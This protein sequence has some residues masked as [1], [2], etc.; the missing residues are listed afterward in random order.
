MPVPAYRR[1]APS[2]PLVI[3]SL[4]TTQS[5]FR[6]GWGAPSSPPYGGPLPTLTP[7]LAPVTWAGFPLP[8]PG[9]SSP[10]ARPAGRSLPAT[11]PTPG[12]GER[13]AERCASCGGSRTP[14][15]SPRRAGRAAREPVSV[16]YGRVQ[17]GVA[18]VG[19]A[20]SSPLSV[21]ARVSRSVKEFWSL[22]GSPEC[23][24]TPRCVPP[25]FG[26]SLLMRLPVS[27]VPAASFCSERSVNLEGEVDWR[28][29]PVIFRF[30]R[31]YLYGLYKLVCSASLRNRSA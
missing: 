13:W 31:V 22:N 18:G 12:G 4:P 15:P 25:R 3:F 26:G 19:L 29:R 9:A 24:S 28:C 7:P 5:P 1:G 17:P 21:S 14:D 30:A 6:T 10:G 11:P 2:F 27:I 23:L 20:P 8:R 16:G